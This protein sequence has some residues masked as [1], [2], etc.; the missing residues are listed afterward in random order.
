MAY[1]GDPAHVSGMTWPC[2]L[3]MLGLGIIISLPLAV[4]WLFKR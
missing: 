4:V 1:P 3:L 2:F